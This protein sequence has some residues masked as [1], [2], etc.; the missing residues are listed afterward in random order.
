MISKELSEAMVELDEILKYTSKDV[1]NRI[2]KKF[3]EFIKQN[4]SSTTY[5]FF[6]NPDKTLEEQNIKL[7]TKVLIALIYKDYLCNEKEKKDYLTTISI[8]KEDMERDKRKLYNTD[9]LFRKSEKENTNSI[10]PIQVKKESI[11]TKI[12]QF[13][14]NIFKRQ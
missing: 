14:K 7:K 3:I 9:K 5:K 10:L 6:Y 2:P 13:L 1:V 8:I 12:I 11:F 4:T